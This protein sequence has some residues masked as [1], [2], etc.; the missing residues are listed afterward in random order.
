MGGKASF[1]LNRYQPHGEQQPSAGQGPNSHMSQEPES[2]TVVEAE[3]LK[4]SALVLGS[5]QASA[6]Q[7]AKNID[8]QTTLRTYQ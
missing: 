5:H 2:D 4:Q 1:D 3:D 8:G 6:P 7:I